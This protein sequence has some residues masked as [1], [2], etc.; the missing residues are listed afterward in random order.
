MLEPFKNWFYVMNPELYK[1]SMVSI[2]VIDALVPFL[3]DIFT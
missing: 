3:G 1:G 2:I